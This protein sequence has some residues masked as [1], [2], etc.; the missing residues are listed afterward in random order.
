MCIGSSES[1]ET[2]LSRTRLFGNRTALALSSGRRRCSEI[3]ERNIMINIRTLWDRVRGLAAAIVCTGL[4]GVVLA[5]K[6]PADVA[7]RKTIVTFSAP[8]E[9]PGKALPA[10]TYVFKL[11]DSTSNRNIVQIY[12]KDEKQL[13]ATILAI[14]DYRM[15]P[16]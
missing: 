4:L 6:A 10:G 11:L 15:Q 7:D 9:V 2:S 1:R 8:V 13:L 5:P 3:K 14:P 12:D 16:S